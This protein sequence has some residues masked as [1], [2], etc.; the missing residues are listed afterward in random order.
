MAPERFPRALCKEE[1]MRVRF[2]HVPV[3]TLTVLILMATPR[4]A[5][6]YPPG[7]GILAKSRTCTS[8]HVDNGPW[9]DE[10]RTIVDVLD[11]TTKQS[12]RA[13]DGAFIVTVPRGATRTVLTVIGRAAGEESPPIRNAWLYVDP[14]QIG[15]SALS[16]FA[17]GWDVNLPMSCRLVGDRLEGF[18]GAHLTVLPMTIRPTDAARDAELELQAMLTSGQAVKGKAREGL[19]SNSLIRKVLLRVVEPEVGGGR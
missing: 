15:T 9:T 11:A 6:A 8:C 1:T 5:S 10:K 12:L 18:E 16:K 2:Q 4:P 14:T 3:T 7:V 13:P 19:I 17:I